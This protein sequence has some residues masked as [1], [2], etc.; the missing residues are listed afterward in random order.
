MKKYRE[1]DILW[2]C[3]AS[4]EEAVQTIIEIEPIGEVEVD[5]PQPSGSLTEHEVVMTEIH[6]LIEYSTKLAELVQQQELSEWMV[7]KIIKAADYVSEVKHRLDTK[8]D[9]AN[10]GYAN[11]DIIELG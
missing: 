4:D 10:T 11:C 8:V 6:K 5:S 3:Y 1:N 2:E 9:F 7:A